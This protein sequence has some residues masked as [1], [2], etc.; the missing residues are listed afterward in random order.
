MGKIPQG[1]DPRDNTKCVPI[2]TYVR[3]DGRMHARAHARIET[4]RN[5][6]KHK[7]AERAEQNRTNNNNNRN[8]TNPLGT[9]GER[10]PVGR[11]V[12]TYINPLLGYRVVIYALLG[13]RNVV[14][15][16]IGR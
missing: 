4:G 5:G 12:D 15:I 8:P 11:Y 13:Q 3:T 1:V 16:Y 7:Q 14:A 9:D 6:K 2:C 10:A